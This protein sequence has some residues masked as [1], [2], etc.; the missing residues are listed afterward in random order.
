MAIIFSEGTTIMTLNAEFNAYCSTSDV[1]HFGKMHLSYIQKNYNIMC[2]KS[3][4]V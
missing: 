4:Y 1:L 2:C 3:Q